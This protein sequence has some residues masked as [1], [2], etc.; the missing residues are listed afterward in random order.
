MFLENVLFYWRVGAEA[1]TKVQTKA[2]EEAPT[3]L[4]SYTV[5]KIT[6][7][8]EDIPSYLSSENLLTSTL[9]YPLYVIEE[10]FQLVRMVLSD[11]TQSLE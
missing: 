11:K 1:P 7:Q 2:P 5:F 9:Y 10:N 8:T 6:P 3:Y 4:P